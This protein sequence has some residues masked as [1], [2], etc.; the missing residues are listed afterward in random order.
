MPGLPTSYYREN[1]GLRILCAGDD[2]SE[3]V[4]ITSEL[5][6][7]IDV[8]IVS[9]ADEAKIA[10][11]GE[12]PFDV[13]LMD[14]QMRKIG[15]SALLKR[16]RDH[17]PDAERIIMSARPTQAA[18]VMKTDCR[19]MRVIRKPCVPD[20]LR[21]AVSDALLRHRARTL[22]ASSVSVTPVS[23]HLSIPS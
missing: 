11:A 4:R 19:V 18:K 14:S 12:L 17:S 10:L 23:A 16:L 13:I 5:D 22:R 1:Q 21:T 7:E 3:L 15:G 6:S 20:V 8:V 2:C 9:S